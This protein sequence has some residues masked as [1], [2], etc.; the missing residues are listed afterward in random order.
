MGSNTILASTTNIMLQQIA[1]DRGMT[2]ENRPV[3]FEKEIGNFKEVGMCGTAAVVVKVKSIERGADKV[4]E[5]NDFDT[6]SSLRAEF[7]GIQ[8]GEKEDKFGWMVEVCDV[9]DETTASMPSLAVESFTPGMVT[10]ETEGSVAKLGP[11]AVHGYERQ[12]LRYVVDHAKSGDPD[13][14]LSAMDQFWNSAL[15]SVGKERWNVRGQVIE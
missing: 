10:A 7:T 2:V 6:I 5:F 14:V 12:L 1:A 9:V 13:S 4:W 15:D 3:D 8:Q 11:Q